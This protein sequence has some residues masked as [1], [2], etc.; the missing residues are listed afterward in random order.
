MIAFV[1]SP[2]GDEEKW[3][4]EYR[5]ASACRAPKRSSNPIRNTRNGAENEWQVL[6]ARDRSMNSRAA[7]CRRQSPGCSR[8]RH[9]AERRQPPKSPPHPDIVP[10]K[11]FLGKQFGRRAIRKNFSRFAFSRRRCVD[12]MP[13]PATGDARRSGKSNR[14]WALFGEH[15]LAARGGMAEAARRSMTGPKGCREFGFFAPFFLT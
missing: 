2:M 15:V 13:P 1:K 14:M 6:K 9:F 3:Q 4:R 5:R 10:L 11:G 8:K 7:S 12:R